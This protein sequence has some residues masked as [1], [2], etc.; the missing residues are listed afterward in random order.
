MRLR[1]LLVVLLLLLTSGCLISEQAGQGNEDLLFHF[2]TQFNRAVLFVRSGAL[3]LV[4][5]W[6]LAASRKKTGPVVVAVAFLAGALYLFVSDYSKLGRYRVEVLADGLHIQIPPEGERTL[7][8]T[9]I[10]EMYVEGL[11]SAAPRG[12]AIAQ[13]LELPEWHRLE[14]TMAGGAKH[15]MDLRALSMEQRQTLWKAIARRAHLV[16]ID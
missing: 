14:L 5:V 13:M 10:D 7:A 4:G 6:L 8:W 3:A 9:G 1:H 12:D 11:G 16:Q 2:D 15:Q